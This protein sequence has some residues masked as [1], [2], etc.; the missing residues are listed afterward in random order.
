MHTAL[1][2]AAAL[3]LGG[4]TATEFKPGPQ[5]WTQ[6]RGPAR[7]GF[8]AAKSPAWPDK[9][10]SDTLKP[11]WVVKD[12]GPSYSGTIVGESLVYTTQTVDKK[13]EVVTA[14]DRTTGKPVW[15]QQW[16]GS[17][18]VPFF[19]NKNG[20]WIRAT[21]LLDGD[22]LY[23][24]GIRDL[25]KCLDAKTGDEKWSF[26]FVKELGSAIPAFGTVCSPMSDDKFLYIQAG[27]HFCKITKDKGKL[28]WKTLKDAGDIMSG[29]SFSCPVFATLAGKKQLLVQGREALFGVD[30][31]N[32]KELWTKKIAT[33]R[34]MNI[35]TP[36]TLGDQV[37]TS[38]YGGTTQ[39]FNVRN[40]GDSLKTE[41][42][43]SLKYEGYMT[44]PVVVADHAYFLGKD[45]KAICVDLKTG[46]E[47]WRSEKTYGDYWSL[48]A[49]GDKILALDSRG[50]LI[51]MKANPKELE[52]LAE[53][54][55]SKSESWAHL[56][57]CGEEV[58]VRDLVSLTSYRWK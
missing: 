14:Y 37:F 1:W 32:G 38:T 25:L 52:I 18:T 49:N 53:H 39:L 36:I 24:P 54:T 50:K 9:L 7:D 47:T 11:N 22:R 34:G 51:L 31:D 29:G 44:T 17:I 21:P 10:D 57:V 27:G 45:K 3:S 30:I 19:A 46:K 16:E 6:W 41:D 48:V 8:V 2:L 5:T 58:F 26:D 43:W 12:L 4:S 56:S 40:S 33:F 15:K 20:S 42:A 35:L 23:V 28:E 55:V 13:T